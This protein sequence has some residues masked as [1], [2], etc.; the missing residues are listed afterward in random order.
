VI[1]RLISCLLALLWAVPLFAQEQQEQPTPF[2]VWLDFRALAQP[3][4]PRIALPIWLASL[5]TERVAA[6]E[7]SPARTIF[8]LHFRRVGELNNSLQL[9]LFFDDVKNNALSVS[10]WSETGT[11]RFDSGLLGS[12]LGLPTSE[13]LTLSM[14]G[15]DYIDIATDGDGSNIRGVFLATLKRANVQHALDYEPPTGVADAF[16]N[17][18]PLTLKADDFALY[19]RVKASL[20]PGVMK[21]APAE[22]PAGSWEFELQSPPLIAVISFEVLDADALAPIEVTVNDRLLGPVSV[23]QPDLADPAFTGLV[24]P[25]DQDMRFRY[26]GWLRATKAIPG[27]ALRAGLNNIVLRLHRESGPAAVR[28]IEIQLKYNSS[29][30]DYTLA[31]NIP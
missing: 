16:E 8:R 13:N 5:G 25:L 20:D 24:R 22:N 15:V 21:L 31:P 10:G 7:T 12:G 27:S 11:A 28:T 14:V 17:L 30:L 23:H 9:R 2:S 26:S 4:P 3:N 6:N 29:T 1:L 18:P 19:G